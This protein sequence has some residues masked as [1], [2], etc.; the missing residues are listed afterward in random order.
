M[1][2]Y[3]SMN[4]PPSKDELGWDLLLVFCR[5]DARALLH[6]STVATTRPL[7]MQWGP[8]WSSGW[9]MQKLLMGSFELVMSWQCLSITIANF[10]HGQPCPWMPWRQVLT[11]IFYSNQRCPSYVVA[12]DMSYHLTTSWSLLVFSK[13]KLLMVHLN[14]RCLGNVLALWSPTFVMDNRAH[15][16]HEDKC[17]RW[18]FIQISDVL[19]MS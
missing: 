4:I 1:V 18:S 7:F 6:D 16:R 14:W 9:W 3:S 8:S 13:F 15:G 12:F 5:K 11:V 19:V 17:S 2:I 10:C